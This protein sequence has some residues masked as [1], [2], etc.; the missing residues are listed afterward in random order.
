ML[1]RLKWNQ[2]DA[3]GIQVCLTCFNGGCGKDK[4]EHSALHYRK[5]GHMLALNLRRVKKQT[6]TR[7]TD[8]QSAASPPQKITKLSIQQQDESELYDIHTS[9]VCL[10]CG[11]AEVDASSSKVRQN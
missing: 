1:I 5:F 11:E 6:S 9:I 10:A 3:R 8:S 7:Q 4:M 2:D